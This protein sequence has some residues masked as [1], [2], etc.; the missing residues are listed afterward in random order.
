MISVTYDIIGLWYHNQYHMQNH[1]WYHRI[2][3][4]ISYFWNYDI[5]N[6]WYHRSMISYMMTSMISPMISQSIPTLTQFCKQMISMWVYPIA[7]ASGAWQRRGVELGSGEERKAAD[8]SLE[9]LDGVCSTPGPRVATPPD[10]GVATT[11]PDCRSLAWWAQHH[12]RRRTAQ[13]QWLSPAWKTQRRRGR[14]RGRGRRPR[15]K[16]V[17]S[18]SAGTMPGSCESCKAWT[19]R[20]RSP[21]DVVGLLCTGHRKRRQSGCRWPWGT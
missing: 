8:W 17:G 7:Q 14:R 11:T 6:L 1:I 16:F 19:H 3:T 18:P 20:R 9:V 4:M 10:A 5:S 2:E 12:S 21:P 15:R 13:A